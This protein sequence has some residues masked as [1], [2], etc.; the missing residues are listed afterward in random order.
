MEYTIYKIY[1][2]DESI[3][4]CYIGSSKA[5]KLRKYK[6]T[7]AA[8]CKTHK[9]H[10]LKLYQTIYNNGGI[11]NW[12]IIPIEVIK[13]ET[14]KEALIREQYWI[15]MYKP[16]LNNSNAYG[17]NIERRKEKEKQRYINNKNKA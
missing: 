4:D 5:F 7:T 8:N 2:N 1:C 12:S 17:L 6:H 9:N 3:T 11:N 10:N 13:C 16:T 14:K 15:N